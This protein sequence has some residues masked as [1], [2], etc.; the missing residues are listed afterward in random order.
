MCTVIIFSQVIFISYKTILFALMCLLSPLSN[1][2]VIYLYV[3]RETNKFLYLLFIIYIPEFICG[4]LYTRQKINKC[5]SVLQTVGPFGNTSN[6]AGRTV[7]VKL[8]TLL[9]A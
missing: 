3:Y 6:F 1:F 5:S 7:C 9:S 8:I 4:N 2:K